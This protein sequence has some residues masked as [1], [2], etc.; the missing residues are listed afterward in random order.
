MGAVLSDWVCYLVVCADETFYCGITTD[1]ARRINQHNGRLPG[2][3]KY[4][5]A[6]R[7]VRLQAF[8]PHPNRSSASQQEHAIKK[9]TRQKKQQLI[10][11]QASL[12]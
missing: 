8:W 9:M 2:G 3:A 11:A 5:A 1:L 6:R 10:T 12:I 7:P 4:T